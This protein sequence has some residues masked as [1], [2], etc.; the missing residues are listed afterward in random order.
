MPIF[1][2]YFVCK[3]SRHLNDVSSRFKLAR[4][5][6]KI[7]SFDLKTFIV[8]TPLSWFKNCLA[9]FECEMRNSRVHV[10]FQKRVRVFHQCSVSS[11]FSVS[12]ASV[13]DK[14]KLM[15]V[16]GRRPSAFIVFECLK[17]R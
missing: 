15:K 2:R 8:L 12:S 7:T 17:P 14:R 16:R 11:V 9:T 1:A 10:I 4:S 3:K 5:V 6:L 13:S